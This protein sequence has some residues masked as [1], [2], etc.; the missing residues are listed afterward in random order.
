[1]MCY[2]P[3]AALL[4]VHPVAEPQIVLLLTLVVLLLTF[5]VVMLLVPAWNPSSCA[6]DCPNGLI[7]GTASFWLETH[8]TPAPPYSPSF[9]TFLGVYNSKSKIKNSTQD[10]A[11]ELTMCLF[12]ADS[13]IVF[14]AITSHSLYTSSWKQKIL[15]TLEKLETNHKNSLW[16]RC[17]RN[18]IQRCARKCRM[19]KSSTKHIFA[20]KEI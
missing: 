14:M 7:C 13:T 6:C 17:I 19:K 1:M 11:R 3:P 5:V 12:D 18:F 10:K 16:L 15:G 2:Y 8:L 20:S 9:R 4:L